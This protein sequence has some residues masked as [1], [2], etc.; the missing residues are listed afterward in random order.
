M[1]W[2]WFRLR[3]QADCLLIDHM[4][5]CGGEKLTKLWQRDEG[6]TG[7][8][9]PR[10]LHALLDICLLEEVA[11]DEKNAIVTYFLLDIV[12]NG[13][14]Q[15]TFVLEDFAVAVGLPAGPRQRTHAFWLFDH[16]EFQNALETFQPGYPGWEE[17]W[18]HIC[19][20][21]AL[22]CQ[23]ETALAMRYVFDFAPKP[24]CDDDI[25]LHLSVLLAN[26]KVVAAW[27]ILNHR[28]SFAVSRELFWHFFQTCISEN[29]MHHVITF[30]LTSMQQKYLVEFL[31][32]NNQPKSQELL[33]LYHMQEANYL[34]A[35]RL[36]QNMRYGL[37]AG[38]GPAAHERY[39]LRNCIMEQYAHVLP[40]V[41]RKLKLD[42]LRPYPKSKHVTCD[43]VPR[44]L[45]TVRPAKGKI[46]LRSTFLSHLLSKMQ[47]VHSGLSQE[48]SSIIEEKNENIMCSKTLGDFLDTPLRQS[49]ISNQKLT[50]EVTA[51]PSVKASPATAITLFSSLHNRLNSLQHSLQDFHSSLPQQDISQ[52]HSITVELL[53][54]PPVVRQHPLVN[55][56][57]KD[58]AFPS[59]NLRTQPFTKT[60][61]SERPQDPRCRSEGWIGKLWQ[62]RDLFPNTRTVPQMSQEVRGNPSWGLCFVHCF[63]L[64][65]PHLVAVKFLQ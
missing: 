22:V 19:I 46:M 51:S 14:Q 49:C 54:T 47:E 63:F 41:Q 28:G 64:P 16:K 1:L 8:Y 44:P 52:Q 29:L 5:A 24:I 18:Q 25:K 7:K 40:C 13:D 43:V 33:W 30:P 50:N 39:M 4:V 58:E 20:L 61:T 35:F 26:R 55:T 36:H 6:G 17:P 42:R 21:Q 45:S 11:M 60:A 31:R 56:A 37:A 59:S 62:E 53:Q 10:T 48:A 15:H 27:R 34:D 57:T 3:W 9:P 23:S 2:L 65:S 12:Y 32:D 38:C